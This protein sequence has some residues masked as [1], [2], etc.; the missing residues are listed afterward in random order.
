MT[1][2]EQLICAIEYGSPKQIPVNVSVL[3]AA[4]ARHGDDLIRLLK[5]YPDLYSGVTSLSEVTL[6]PSYHAGRHVDEWG[7]VWEN[8]Q[9]G[10]EAIVTEHPLPNRED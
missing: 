8:L 4:F 1:L 2:E 3:P 6:P 10:M 7:C 9:E 5:E